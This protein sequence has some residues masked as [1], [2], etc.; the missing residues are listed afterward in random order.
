[1][2]KYSIAVPLL[3]LI[4]LNVADTYFTVMFVDGTELMDGNPVMAYLLNKGAFWFIA[5]K[6]GLIFISSYLLYKLRGHGWGKPLAW[7]SVLLYTAIV[8]YWTYG[9]IWVM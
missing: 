8:L 5:V 3:L 6:T 7:G 1:M 4:A 2:T 9:V